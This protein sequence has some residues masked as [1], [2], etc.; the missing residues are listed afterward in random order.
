M[1]SFIKP[2]I[3]AIALYHSLPFGSLIAFF[4]VYLGIVNNQNL[5]RFVRFNAM[6]VR[7]NVLESVQ[8]LI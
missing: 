8:L 1:K 2:F 5:S 4:G 7:R 3:P 6:Q